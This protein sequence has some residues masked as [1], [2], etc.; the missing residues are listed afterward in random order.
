[1]RFHKKV[2]VDLLVKMLGFGITIGVIFPFFTL[3]FKV[4]K[5]IAL[6]PL[7]FISCILAGI[8]VGL[9][10][11]VI[12]K[13]SVKKRLLNL[14]YRMT[15][16]ENSITQ[17]QLDNLDL[18]LNSKDYE[19]IEESDDCFGQMAEA[20]NALVDSLLKTLRFQKGHRQY[21]E[22]LSENLDLTNLSECAVKIMMGLSGSSAG[23][24]LIEKDGELVIE[25][26]HGIKNSADLTNNS[27][28]FSVIKKGK[29]EVLNF[30]ETIA[31]DGVLTDYRPSQLILE[32]VIYN[33]IISGVLILACTDKLQ[34]EFLK[35][36]DIFMKSLSVILNNSLQHERMQKLAAIDPLTGI[37]NRRFG[38]NRLKEECA[39]S[40]RFD[41]PLGIIMLDID[42]FK[43]VNDTYGHSAGDRIIKRIVTEIQ[44]VLRN[45]DIL[46]R[47]G[48]E[49]FLVILPGANK[50]NTYRVAERIRYSV[51]QAVTDYGENKIKV[52]VSLG[53]DSYPET[54]MNEPS[55]LIDNADK[56][57]YSAKNSGRN[58]S[59]I[60]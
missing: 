12:V 56:A 33:S 2:F 4:D 37:Y 40:I 20:F 52:T 7:F 55:E 60:H 29:R 16:V 23:A 53:I 44:H 5:T 54:S 15:A 57:L 35:H 50:E 25:A 13:A 38:L 11:F 10:S 28:I 3:L 39:R 46:I 17:Y 1:M 34:P 21:I 30:P 26:S 9:I 14:I 8:L 49:E 43:M 36:L 58:K 42:K 45:G 32:P 41:S 24:L 19:I 48:G 59:V 18:S 31:L 27:L 6:S 22:E 47:Y 51:E